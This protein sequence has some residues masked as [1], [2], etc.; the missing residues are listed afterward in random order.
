MTRF[1]ALALLGS[2]AAL[3]GC[4]KEGDEQGEGPLMAAGQDCLTC[5]GFSAAGTVFAGP[6]STR[7]ASGATVVLR[8][9]S[10]ALATLTSNAAGNFYT[11]QP[12]PA[13]F[14]VEITLGADT[15]TMAGAGKRCN[16]CHRAGGVQ[17]PIH[18]P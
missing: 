15:R 12:L 9:G 13:S 4:G 14:D 6:G 18:V 1:L 11:S 5:H 3:S 2:L 7:G 17:P 16:N 10:T 8:S